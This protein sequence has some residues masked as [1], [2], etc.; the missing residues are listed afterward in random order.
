MCVYSAWFKRATTYKFALYFVQTSGRQNQGAMPLAPP[1]PT[2][3]FFPNQKNKTKRPPLFTKKK[4]KR[5]VII[6]AKYCIADDLYPLC[7]HQK[8]KT[9]CIVLI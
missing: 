4:E 9:L 3:H 6:K 7:M 5:R 2:P 8:I 1:C